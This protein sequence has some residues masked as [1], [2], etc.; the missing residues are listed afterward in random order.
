[1]FRLIARWHALFRLQPADE[2][3]AEEQ[4][5]VVWKMTHCVA[6][7]NRATDARDQ[8]RYY[9]RQHRLC[10]TQGSIAVLTEL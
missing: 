3:L 7:P 1:V 10:R 6:S 5:F 4:V 9:K 8:A 2:M